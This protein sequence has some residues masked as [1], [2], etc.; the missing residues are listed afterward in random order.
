MRLN[1]PLELMHFTLTYR[2]SLPC[3]GKNDARKAEKHEIRRAF[4]TQL[5]E[6]WQQKPILRHAVREWSSFATQSGLRA[7]EKYAALKKYEEELDQYGER[8]HIIRS[9]ERG[10]ALFVPLVSSHLNLIC[11]LDILFLRAEPP[12]K[13]FTTNHA[14][15]LDNRLKVLFDALRMPADVNE[16][17]PAFEPSP[18]EQIC[19]CLLENDNLVTAVRLE[20]ERLLDVPAST[21]NLVELV[22]RVAIKTEHLTLKNLEIVGGG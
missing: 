7:D 21:P 19:Y 17:P 6:L 8:K 9:F 10:Q 18:G 3:Q 4:S 12:G 14:G 2:G 20:S 22:V 13:L 11:E 16:L 1:S 15:D 5:W